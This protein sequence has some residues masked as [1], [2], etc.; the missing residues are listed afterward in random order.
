MWW[1]LAQLKW[2]LYYFI[3]KFYGRP[4]WRLHAYGENMSNL[5]IFYSQFLRN[6]LRYNSE[7]LHRSLFFHDLSSGA[8]SFS[9]SWFWNFKWTYLHFVFVVFGKKFLATFK[10][11][12]SDMAAKRLQIFR[13]MATFFMPDPSCLSYTHFSPLQP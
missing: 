2:V 6:Y 10:K 13:G 9:I 12:R 11:K 1:W 8:N 4:K 7:N 5:S 3:W